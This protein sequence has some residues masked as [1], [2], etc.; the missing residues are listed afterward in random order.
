MAK[1]QSNYR[2]ITG[3]QFGRLKV[4]YNVGKLGNYRTMFWC[5]ECSCGNKKVV[6]G[7]SLWRGLILSCGCFGKERRLE[8]IT[9]H[10]KSKTRIY[11]VWEAM[12]S[13]CHNLK[14]ITYKWYGERGIKVCDRW[15]F[16]FSS[17]FEDMGEAPSKCCLERIDN[18]KGYSK[19]NVRWATMSEQNR[20]KRSNRVESFRGRTMILTDWAKELGV[21]LNTLSWRMK[22]W[23]K[24]RALTT[25]LPRDKS[26]RVR[27]HS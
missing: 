26:G 22:K 19:D 1:G 27:L 17:F 21:S 16:S 8:A 23:G 15:R 24:E 12:I 25:Y 3:K 4:L 7:R 20:N 13:R 10:G 9:T 2:D 18:N 6:E 14:N 11:E 5:C